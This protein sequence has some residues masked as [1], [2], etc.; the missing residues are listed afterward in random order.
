M[1]DEDNE[2]TDI[3]SRGSSDLASGNQGDWPHEDPDESSKHASAE[4]IAAA[5]GGA[6]DADDAKP[7]DAADVPVPSEDAADGSSETFP[8]VNS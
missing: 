4:R 7:G 6:D 3:A 5:A 2:V 8:P 1:A